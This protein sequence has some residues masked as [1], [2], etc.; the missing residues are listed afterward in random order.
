MRAMLQTAPMQAADWFAGEVI[1]VDSRLRVSSDRSRFEDSEARGELLTAL[2]FDLGKK[3]SKMAHEV[4]RGVS[5]YKSVAQSKDIG[6]T[7]RRIAEGNSHIS[8]Q[9]KI[10]KIKE[11]RRIIEK[12][13]SIGR[14]SKNRRE[15]NSAQK[16]IDEVRTLL[17]RINNQ[18]SRRNDIT[19]LCRFSSQAKDVYNTVV[20]A[21]VK[22]YCADGSA[23]ELITEI[24]RELI[25]KYG[26]E[27][28]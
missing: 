27:K 16:Q 8:E 12:L 19:R 15:A 24:E 26:D 10:K 21:I 23:E 25:R 22:H 7:L 3:L 11:A 17:D 4:S 5:K 18:R 2:R 14:H 20:K 13:D 1:V 9:H 28:V 6:H